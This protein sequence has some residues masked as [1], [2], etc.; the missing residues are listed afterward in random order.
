VPGSLPDHRFVDLVVNLPLDYRLRGA[1]DKWALKAIA[2]RHLPRSIVHR[3]KVGFPLPIAD[4]LAPLARAEFFR[5]GFCE[6]GLGMDRRGLRATIA[7]WRQ[8]VHGFLS[9]LAVEIWGRLLFRRESAEDVSDHL[10][11]AASGDNGV[12]L[13]ASAP[14]Q[15]AG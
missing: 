11:V 7:A 9:L 14:G 2:G 3:R 12:P 8:N 15:S 13:I 6:Q 4:Y 1:T 10:L 5:D